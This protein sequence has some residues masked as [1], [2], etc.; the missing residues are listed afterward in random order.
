M[1]PSNACCV[2]GTISYLSPEIYTCSLTCFENSQVSWFLAYIHFC[3]FIVVVVVVVLH[4][5]TP[6][7]V[8]AER[9][10]CEKILGYLVKQGGN[11]DTKDNIGVRTYVN[12]LMAVELYW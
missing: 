9:G 4:Q 1:P 2:W 10:R 6:L 3:F 11:I 8:G 5:W 12:V 7:H